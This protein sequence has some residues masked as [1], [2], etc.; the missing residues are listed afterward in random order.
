MSNGG[1]MSDRLRQM[2]VFLAVCDARGFTAAARRLGIAPS[3]VTRL[4]GALEL[5]LGV[6]LLQRTTRAIA[7]TD[8]GARFL[9]RCRLI[10]AQ[11]E[12]AEL[13]AQQERGVPRGRLVVSAPLL[14]GR[15]H[16]VPVVSSFLERYP[17]VQVELGLTDRVVNLVEEG[18]DV[19]VRIGRLADSALIAR[20]IGSTSRILVASPDYLLA[21]KPPQRPEDLSAHRLIVF[22]TAVT[23]REW[24]FNDGA[25][26][27]ITVPL[28]PRFSTN[29]ADAAID[30]AARAGGIASVYRYQVSAALSDGRLVEILPNLAS[31]EVPVQALFPTT[32][33]LSNKVRA[34]LDAIEQNSSKW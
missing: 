9:E 2:R 18:V 26:G 22:H 6:V 32:R 17:D 1:K 5:D 15:M 3:V 28:N 13:A 34:F 29:S 27:S 21:H 25:G 7:L 19:T 23:E 30:H 4:I 11:V 8:P 12:E 14:F 20:R 24:R 16:L 10:L 33:L 31:E